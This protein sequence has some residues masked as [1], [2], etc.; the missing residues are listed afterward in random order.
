MSELV[1]DSW[2]LTDD[3]TGTKCCHLP[4]RVSRRMPVTDIMLWLECY[5]TLATV[6]STQYPDKSVEFWVYQST[7]LRAHRDFE[8]EAWVTY[9]TCYRRQ[10][11]NTKSLN[12]SQIDFTLYNQT[13]AGKARM[14]LR[15]ALC[16]SEHHIT[17][18]CDFA[19]D[20]MATRDIQSSRPTRPVQGTGRTTKTPTQHDT[21]EVCIL[22]NADRGNI[23]R[24]SRCKYAHV[25]GFRWCRGPH[26]KSECP[27]GRRWDAQ[28]RK[29]GRSP[30]ANRTLLPNPTPQ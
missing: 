2:R 5:S 8:G 24:Y 26:P 20:N 23:C 19:T 18:N 30:I 27:G 17:G 11:A 25:C 12:W 14:K 6:L 28:T 7:I 21:I 1:P 4:R 29:R 9:D 22:F 3:D 13:F 10:A 16:L 15:C